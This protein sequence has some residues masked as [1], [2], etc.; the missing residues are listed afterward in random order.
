MLVLSRKCDE[1]IMIADYIRV[2]V[3]EIRGNKVRIGVEAPK[4][5]RVDRGEVWDAIQRQEG[6]DGALAKAG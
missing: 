5:V 2:R 6:G 1:E 3:L 4:D